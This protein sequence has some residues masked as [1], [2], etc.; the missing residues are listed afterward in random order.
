MPTCIR[1]HLAGSRPETNLV[2]MD[3]DQLTN[4]LKLLTNTTPGDTKIRR[5]AL[6]PETTYR[7]DKTDHVNFD[8]KDPDRKRRYRS[9]TGLVLSGMQQQAVMD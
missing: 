2:E 1:D 3:P 7:Q 9:E 5:Q 4:F 6:A 8:Y